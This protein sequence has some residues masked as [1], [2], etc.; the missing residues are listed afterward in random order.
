MA[1]VEAEWGTVRDKGR[2]EKIVIIITI[3]TILINSQVVTTVSKEDG[4][5]R[6][7][8]LQS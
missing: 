5:S 2:H 4:I 3:V 1:T 6:R 8:D 7:R